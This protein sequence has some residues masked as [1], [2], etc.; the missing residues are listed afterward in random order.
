[1][2]VPLNLISPLLLITGGAVLS[3]IVGIF[4][5]RRRQGL[6]ALLTLGILALASAAA[7]HL[8]GT[9]A[10]VFAGTYA[11]DALSLWTG[12]LICLAGALT[13]L[14]AWPVFRGDAREAEFYSLLLFSIG[15]ALVLA[16]A[17]DLM[18]MLLGILLSSI[19]AYVLVAYRRNDPLALEAALKFYLFGALTNAGL[20]LGL[21]YL[22]GLSGSTL[23]AVIPAHLNPDNAALLTLAFVLILT[24]LAFKAG[25]VPGHFWMPD[26][27]QGTSVPVAAFLSIVPKLAAFAALI[28]ITQALPQTNWAPVLAVLSAVTMTWGNLAAFRQQDLK[29]LLAYSSISQSGYLLLGVIAFSTTPLG[30]TVMLYYFAAYLFANLAAFA[31]LSA[32]AACRLEELAG[33][34]K[35]RPWL[36]FS[37]L[38]ALLSLMGLPPLAGFIG[39]FLLFSA[40]IG[41]GYAWLAILAAINSALSLYYYLR[42]LAPI[43]LRSGPSG[44][45]ASP[46]ASGIALTCAAATLILGIAA[47][48]FTGRAA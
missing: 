15:G 20:I 31:V 2:T 30:I 40:A 6:N 12:V 21:S 19:P 27:F 48:Y 42:V 43:Y 37:M 26:V 3:L 23:L 18:E 9:Q 16:G 10:L 28:R 39:K 35:R 34:G 36:A 41:A 33:L 46:V 17:M 24:G 7:L 8:R 44:E 25:F 22:Y 45:R 1:M 29:R 13:T 5:P 14:L 32:T 4:L 11:V 38:A 47:Y